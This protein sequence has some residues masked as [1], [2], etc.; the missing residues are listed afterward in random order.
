MHAQEWARRILRARKDAH[1]VL[2][3]HESSKSRVILLEDLVKSMS[4]APVDVQDYF[5]EAIDCL[6]N[7]LNRSSIIMAWAGHFSLFSEKLLLNHQNDIHCARPKWSFTDLADLKEQVPESQIL[8]VARDVGFIGKALLKM[9]QGQLSVR[10]QCA[11]PT[12]FR[13]NMNTAIG[14]VD[15]MIQQTMPYV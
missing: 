15:D 1:L 9:K 4:G 12:L 8:D 10:N 5:R 11:H 3:S 2:A 6:E 13:P 14:Y 7:G